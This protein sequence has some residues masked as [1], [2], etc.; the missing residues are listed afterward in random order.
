RSIADLSPPCARDYMRTPEPRPCRS[1]SRDAKTCSSLLLQHVSR[2]FHHRVVHD[3]MP[4]VSHNLWLGNPQHHLLAPLLKAGEEETGARGDGA[5]TSA[6]AQ[7]FQATL[8]HNGQQVVL[9]ARIC[10]GELILGV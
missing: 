2:C 5:D 7:Q 10:F 8:H 3:A 6:S 4:Q 1:R 9:T